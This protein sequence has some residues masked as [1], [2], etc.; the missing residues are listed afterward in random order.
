V[1]PYDL[2]YNGW[3]WN[4]RNDSSW[5]K[6]TR[7]AID[8]FGFIWRTSAI[9]SMDQPIKGPL[10]D[11]WHLLHDYKLPNMKD[12]ARFAPAKKF[13]KSCLPVGSVVLFF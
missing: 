5:L 3:K 2:K 9:A 6:E 4:K 12:P 8:E 11:G 10:E 7:T 1:H 13:L